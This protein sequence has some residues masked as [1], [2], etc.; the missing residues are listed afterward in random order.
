MSDLRKL[1]FPISILYKSVTKTRNTLYDKGILKSNEFDIPLIVVG[2]LRVGGTGKSPMVAYLV[3]LLKKNYKIAVLSRGYKRKTKGFILG[4]AYATAESIGDEPFQLFRQHPDI[5]VAVDEDRTNGIHTLE[6][7][8]EKPNLI[9][10]DDAFQHRKVKA[11][12]N[13]LLTSYDDLYIDDALLP[14]GNLRESVEGADRAQ[15]IV[16]TKCPENFSDKQE[17]ETAVKLKPA[18]TQ[19]VFFSKIKYADKILNESNAIAISE[20]KGY[21][22]V[23]VT[24]IAN[25]KP[26]L[27]F[28]NSENI[29]Y[30]HV[31]FPDHHNFSKSDLKNIQ[32]TFHKIQSNKK[33]IL[34]TEKDYVRIF[35][36]FID[37]Y[38]LAIETTFVNHQKDFEKLILN[39]VEQST[40]NS[41]VS[42]R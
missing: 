5:L 34:T 41:S 3:N 26:L 20:L 4:D 21:K 42:K 6:K 32:D 14:S 25:P 38:Y 39:Y 30:Q 33:L 28:L 12:F 11:D 36:S 27:D 37:L 13:I 19:T 2:N 40:R 22:V 9:L 7:L 17:F 23:L 24:G 18:L 31:S 1:L 8:A 35:G 16:V 29:N 15:V 10:L